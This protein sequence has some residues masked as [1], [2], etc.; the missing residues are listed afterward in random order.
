M[1]RTYL[2][3]YSRMLTIGYYK[4]IFRRLWDTR[5]CHRQPLLTPMY[6]VQGV[7]FGRHYRPFLTMNTVRSN[8]AYYIHFLF[9]TGSPHTYL[10][11]DV[12]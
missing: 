7:L 12:C 5:I 2:M 10:S 6:K 1:I 9:D 3:F 8:R 11:Q 4:E